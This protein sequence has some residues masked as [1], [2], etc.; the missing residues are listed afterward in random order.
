MVVAGFFE[1]ARSQMGWKRGGAVESW[2]VDVKVVHML[3]KLDPWVQ[4]L[5]TYFGANFFT[6]VDE[7]AISCLK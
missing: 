4:L 2:R 5:Y 3:K 1:R 7:D 6:T